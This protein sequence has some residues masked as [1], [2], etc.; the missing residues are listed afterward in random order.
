MIKKE[1]L[2]VTRTQEVVYCDI[3]SIKIGLNFNPNIHRDEQE[4]LGEKCAQLR[5]PG[6]KSADDIKYICRACYRGRF[7]PLFQSPIVGEEGPE[8][9]LY[10]DA[11][12]GVKIQNKDGR[13]AEGS[14]CVVKGDSGKY[15]AGF[16]IE[17]AED[18]TRVLYA[19]DIYKWVGSLEL[20]EW[21]NEHIKDV[22]GQYRN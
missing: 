20:L 14:R 21:T 22:L 8:I 18:M 19:E 5:I 13:L 7:G 6:S 3:C 12:Y 11:A 17:V 4:D 15:M 16:V 1:V 9:S 2:P 10:Q